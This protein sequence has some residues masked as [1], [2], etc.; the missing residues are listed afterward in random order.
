[1]L[2]WT[3]CSKGDGAKPKG[4]TDLEARCEQLGKFCGD[5]DK[6]IGKIADECKAA[7]KVQIEKGCAD[8][9]ITLF[10]CYEK[11]VCGINDKVWA[12]GDIRVLAARKTKCVAEQAA[13]TACEDKK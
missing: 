2:T 12:L 3:A 5:K 10:D 7:A 8:K 9:V 6:H 11:D 13:V 4:G 1:M